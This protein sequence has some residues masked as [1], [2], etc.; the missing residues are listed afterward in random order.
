MIIMSQRK[1]VAMAG[2]ISKTSANCAATPQQN[3]HE[4]QKTSVV[5]DGLFGDVLRDG[6]RYKGRKPSFTRTQFET[7][8][9]MIGHQTGVSI[10]ARATGLSRQTIYPIK[11]DAAGSE[12]AL[13]TWG[14]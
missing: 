2:R 9:N 7:V 4:L 8:Q 3:P 14:Q 11:D 6:E 13:A 12:A 1:N 10:I 5:E